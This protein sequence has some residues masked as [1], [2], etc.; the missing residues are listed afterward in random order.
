[1]TDELLARA[2]AGL[3]GETPA[4]PRGLTETVM[5]RVRADLRPG[6]TFT[7]PCAEGT[8]RVTE[9][10]LRDELVDALDREGSVVVHE[11]GIATVAGVPST[12]R[13]GVSRA[14]DTVTPRKP[15][16]PRSS[17]R[18]TIRDRAAGARSSAG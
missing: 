1:M 14:S 8:A 15:S 5:R 18:T 2:T 11:C 9:A 6:S 12:A 10:V 16:R 7:M 4:P 13:A 3:R 17:P